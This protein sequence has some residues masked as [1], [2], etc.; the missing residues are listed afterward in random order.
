MHQLINKALLSF[1]PEYNNLLIEGELH[2]GSWNKDLH[3]KISMNNQSYSI[4]F[5]GDNRSSHN[6]FGEITDEILTEQI[7]YTDYLIQRGV[8][9]A[10]AIP[11]I[12]G[13][14]FVSIEWKGSNYRVVLFKWVE[15]QHITKCT[16]SFTKLVGKTVKNIHEVSR[17]FR[18]PVF[19]QNSH[20]AGYTKFIAQIKQKRE[21][22]NVS[23]EMARTLNSYLHIAEN[24]INLSKS[25]KLDF[26][27]QSDLNPLNVLWNNENRLAG[28]VDFESIG[29]TDRI[30]GLAWLIKWYS[31]NNGI[32]STRLSPD[33]AKTFFDAY[34]S[35]KTISV[36]EKER[37][38]SL[39]WLSG[40]MNW[41]F[42][43]RTIEIMDLNEETTM[44]HHISFYVSRG[45][46]LKSLLSQI[47]V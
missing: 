19:E 3:Y 24:H 2:I 30:E 35:E 16:N 43:K 37:L 26:I 45:E 13:D 18:S 33:L 22:T 36:E 34:I 23:T 42:V 17:D 46:K 9:F 14:S 28:I 1:F 25:D 8:P 7:R 5:I 44:K 47:L 40:C 41:N 21:I 27:V 4:R 38:Q 20:L 39:L 6:V 10:E 32:G 29:Y 11:S 15:G 12:N 31:R